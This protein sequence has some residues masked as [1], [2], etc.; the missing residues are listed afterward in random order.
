MGRTEEALR[1]FQR[2]IN[3]A[4]VPAAADETNASET[5]MILGRFE[6]AKKILDQ[7]RQKGALGSNQRYRLAFFENDAATMERLAREIPA[8]DLRWLGLQEQLAFFRG[9][10]SKLR[11]LSETL[12]NQQRRAKRMENAADELAWHA[13]LESYLGNYALA[14]KLCRQAG[15]AGKDSNL[16]LGHCAKA[17]A[18][19][20]DVTQAEALAAKL[21]RLRPED[22]LNQGVHL[23]LIRSI[24]ERE[25]GSAAKAVDLLA[26][27]AQ[28]EQGELQVLYYR[29]R[30]YLA[31]G[32]HAKA[33][34]EFARLIGHRGWLDSEVFAPLAQLGLARAYAMQGD[35]EKSRKAYDDF[36]TTWKDADPDTPTL[37]QAKAEYK[38]LTATASAAASASRKKQ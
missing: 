30:A 16:G 3:L 6:E 21:D 1:E 2:A 31:A 11:S 13:R 34:A 15:E 38:K 32:E 4:V 23:P 19:A 22:T 5:L 27:V 29:A 25:R 26:P 28:Y 24:M 35:R 18:E 12:V 9:D 17:L 37:R 36:F 8:D 7:W 33:A 10:F 14:R 20:G